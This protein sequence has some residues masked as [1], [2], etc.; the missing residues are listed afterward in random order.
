[1]AQ[2][3]EPLAP[4]PRQAADFGPSSKLGLHRTA[5][6]DA[7]RAQQA[8]S[9]HCSLAQDALAVIQALE[10]EVSGTWVH[11]MRRQQFA[12]G[13]ASSVPPDASCFRLL[14]LRHC[15]GCTA[16]AEPAA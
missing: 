7:G 13:A 9:P 4:R 12:L 1:M 10:A 5:R 2:P 14:A 11:S 15:L 8:G 16:H 3:R 6:G